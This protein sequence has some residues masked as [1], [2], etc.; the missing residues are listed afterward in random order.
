MKTMILGLAA[1]A[2]LTAGAAAAQPYGYGYGR[3][4]VRV[5][6]DPEQREEMLDF[7]I[8]QG[9]RSGQLTRNEAW[10]LRAQ[11]RQITY[12]EDRYS[13]NG[14]SSWELA[15]LDRRFDALQAQIRFERR[16]GD[17]TYGYN[18]YR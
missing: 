14:L 16:D 5:Y 10:R 8:D 1:A 18:T 15:D 2:A 4:D 11:L 13:R 6:A 12:I 17:R 9:M 3:D 7:R